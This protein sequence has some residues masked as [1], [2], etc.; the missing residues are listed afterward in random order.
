[1]HRHPPADVQVHSSEELEQAVGGYIASRSQLQWWPF[2]ADSWMTEVE[3]VL[4]QL[5]RLI[6]SGQFRLVSTHDVAFARDWARAPRIRELVESDSRLANGDMKFD[7]V[8]SGPQE[9]RF[10]DRSVPLRVRAGIDLVQ[11]LED[12]E[13]DPLDHVDPDLVALR[14]FQFLRWAIEGKTRLRPAIPTMFDEWAAMGVARMRTA[15]SMRTHATAGHIRR[16][17]R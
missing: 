12:H 1:M 2:M 15:V 8:V 10:V 13:I 6:K 4:E 5:T 16:A 11:L 17:V 14:W 7:H 9:F 3:A